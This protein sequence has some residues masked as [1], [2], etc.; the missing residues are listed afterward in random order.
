MSKKPKPIRLLQ[1]VIKKIWTE[2]TENATFLDK[3]PLSYE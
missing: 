1:C 3:Y 2:K